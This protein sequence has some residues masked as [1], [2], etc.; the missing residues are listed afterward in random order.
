MNPESNSQ[1]PGARSRLKLC[2]ICE[3]TAGGVRKHL[4]ELVR[5]FARPEECF[6]IHMLLGDRGEPGFAAELEQF[7][8][9]GVQVDILPEL[10]REIQPMQDWR[11]YRRLK[12][13][14]RALAPDIVHT[15]GSKAGFLGRLAAHAAG[16]RRIVHTPHVFPFQWTTGLR[17][18][19][20]LVLERHAAQRCHALVCVGPGQ[21]EEALALNVGAAGRFVLIPNGVPLLPEPTAE[22][23]AQLRKE[24]HVPPDAEVVGMVARLAPQKGVRFFLDAAVQ[25]LRERPQAVFVLAGGGPLEHETRERAAAAGLDRER[26]KILGHREDAE[27]LYPAFDVLVLSSLYEGLPYVLLEAMA[28]GVPVV[29][30]DVAGSRDVLALGDAGLLAQPQELA[31]PILRLL[32]D[33][34]LRKQLGAQ[35]RQR[36]RETFSLEQFVTGHQR[37]YR[38]KE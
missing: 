28:C 8:A 26:M 19:M 25:V 5:V 7:R 3:A 17:R 12:A 24:L 10:A 33:A 38:G 16:V 27:R 37:L 14:L 4:R 29:A 18:S 23:V 35:A 36:V 34:N 31:A 21:R 22:A 15:H 32:G 11:A 20:Y 6:E 13:R 30:T 1:A 9:A 2:Y